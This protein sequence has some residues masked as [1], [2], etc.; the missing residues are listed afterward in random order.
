MHFTKESVHVAFDESNDLYSKHIARN[1]NIGD[2]LNLEN[3]E[4]SQE[5]EESQEGIFEK[6]PHQE[7]VLPQ[8]ELQ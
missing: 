5:K 3:L 7:A 1:E 8:I 4:I 6:E 2:E